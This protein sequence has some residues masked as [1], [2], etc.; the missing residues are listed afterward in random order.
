MVNIGTPMWCIAILAT[1]LT[2]VFVPGASGTAQRA[3]IR[4]I[5][6]F[7]SAAP[8][9]ILVTLAI[10]IAAIKRAE[11]RPAQPLAPRHRIVKLFAA[12]GTSQHV[13]NTLAL[14]A[15]G[16]GNHGCFAFGRKGIGLFNNSFGQAHRA[17]FVV[18][19]PRAKQAMLCLGDLGWR[20]IKSLAANAAGKSSAFLHSG[21]A[22]LVRTLEAA[23]KVSTVFQTHGISQVGYPTDGAC[24]IYH[25]V[26]ITQGWD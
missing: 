23:C 26:I 6:S 8:R 25:V 18:A 2:S 10:G 21:T 16:R 20:A 3:P 1:S 4:A 12:V 19:L 13:K 15:T 9:W 5:V 7:V 24:T 17:R 14:W 22:V 11:G